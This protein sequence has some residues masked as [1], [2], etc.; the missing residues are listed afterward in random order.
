MKKV[1]EILKTILLVIWQLPQ[2]IIGI[3]LLW[4]YCGSLVRRKSNDKYYVL[5]SCNMPGGI[6]LGMF[7]LINKKMFTSNTIN[8]EYGHV[9]QS[10]ILGPL[11]LLVIGIPSILWAGFGKNGNAYYT[12]Y[13]EKWADRLGGVD[14]NKYSNLRVV[15]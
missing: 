8:H 10:R 2:T 7:V 11:Y 9:K 15:D 3:F 4:F 5:Y 13:T 6:S 14:R 1:L 12:F